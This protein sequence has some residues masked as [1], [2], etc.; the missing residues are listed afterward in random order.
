MKLSEPEPNRTPSQGG[1]GECRLPRSDQRHREDDVPR[2]PLVDMGVCV[3]DAGKGVA[4][5]DDRLQHAGFHQRRCFA[6]V[7]LARH[8]ASATR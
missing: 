5:V 4:G 6:Q 2:L 1:V 3:G 7:R 8:P